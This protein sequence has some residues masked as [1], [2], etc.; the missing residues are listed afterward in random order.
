MNYFTISVQIL[1][2]KIRRNYE[3]CS[4]FSGGCEKNEIDR[5]CNTITNTSLKHLEKDKLYGKLFL[6]LFYFRK[7]YNLF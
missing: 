2:D 3:I 6:F 5:V 7:I 1:L 4:Y